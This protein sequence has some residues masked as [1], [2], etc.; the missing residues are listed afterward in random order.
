MF[1]VAWIAGA[2]AFVALGAIGTFISIFP[3]L[4]VGMFTSD[5]AVRDASSRYLH[6]SSPMLAFIG[7]SMGLYFASQGAAKIVGPV[8][9]QSGRLVFVAVGGSLLTAA[10]AS[11]IAFFML[12][13]GSMLM[14]GLG[15]VLAVY[16]SAWGPKPAKP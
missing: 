14:L 9:S 11:D 8:L 15:T 10:G 5:A 12:A 16:L 6:I 2:A 1:G 7:L 3:E 13:A 4:W